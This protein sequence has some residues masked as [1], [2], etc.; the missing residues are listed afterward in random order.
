MQWIIVNGL[1][2]GQ[3][4]TPG[5]ML[6]SADVASHSSL[7]RCFLHWKKWWLDLDLMVLALIMKPSHSIFCHKSVCPKWLFSSLRLR[8]YAHDTQ[9][10]K[11]IRACVSLPSCAVVLATCHRCGMPIPSK[12]LNLS[13]RHLHWLW[14]C[15]ERKRKLNRSS[16][17][18]L[19]QQNSIFFVFSFS[20]NSFIG[21][22]FEAEASQGRCCWTR[23]PFFVMVAASQ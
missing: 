14:W 7:Q 8:A 3:F 21:N 4:Q 1:P 10:E 11:I 19:N 2:A 6:I 23:M 20:F 12:L 9:H 16:S 5:P 13:L 15:S 17:P 18:A 22:L